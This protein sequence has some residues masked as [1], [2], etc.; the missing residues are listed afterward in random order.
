MDLKQNKNW[1]YTKNSYV[2][3]CLATAATFLCGVET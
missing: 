3:V 2:C 1:A